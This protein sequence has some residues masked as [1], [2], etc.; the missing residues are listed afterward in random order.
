MRVGLLA[1]HVPEVAELDCNPVI[2]S[3]DGAVVV[4]VKVHLAPHA[5]EAPEGLRRLR[6]PRGRSLLAESWREVSPRP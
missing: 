3:A 5:P 1:E 6:P 4:D 2:V